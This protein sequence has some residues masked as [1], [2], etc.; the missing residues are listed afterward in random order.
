MEGKQIKASTFPR[1]FSPSSSPFPNPR[2]W[3]GSDGIK[4]PRRFIRDNLW[5]EQP[6]RGFGGAELATGSVFLPAHSD[7]FSLFQ[8]HSSGAHLF[9][10][11]INTWSEITPVPGGRRAGGD[12][13][14]DLSTAYSRRLIDWDQF[15]L[16]R[17]RFPMLPNSR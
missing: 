17:Q 13:I 4:H 15:G 16:N 7:C 11:R 1:N 10:G 9:P 3:Q 5:P 14:M 2:F 12:E 6:S 8:R